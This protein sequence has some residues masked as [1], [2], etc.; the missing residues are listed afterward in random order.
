MFSED[1][2]SFFFKQYVFLSKK[3]NDSCEQQMKENLTCQE[4]QSLHV[5]HLSEEQTFRLITL[6]KNQTSIVRVRR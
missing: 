4:T 1:Y 5:R 3:G 6:Y 2:S